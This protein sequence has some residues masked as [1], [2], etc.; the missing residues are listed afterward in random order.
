MCEKGEAATVSS[1]TISASTRS[2][3]NRTM[4]SDSWS[5]DSRAKN[6]SS[7][8][9]EPL[10]KDN[11]NKSLSLHSCL[12]DTYA[13]KRQNKSSSN[14]PCFQR[15]A[16]LPNK[17]LDEKLR[18]FSGSSELDEVSGLFRKAAMLG[19]AAYLALVAFS[20]MITP[21]N[22]F[23]SLDGMERTAH[24]LTAVL[25]V[26]TNGSRIFPLLLRDDRRAFVGSG[27]IF[28]TVMVQIIAV[29]ANLAVAL[30]PT[31]V[32]VDKFTGVRS[33]QLRWA[34]MIPL[35]FLMSF[36]TDNVNVQGLSGEDKDQPRYRYSLRLAISTAAGLILPMATDTL[37]WMVV[38][39]FS[40][41]LYLDIFCK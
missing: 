13:A 37:T 14:P 31:P 22:D 27:F 1:E 24:L 21:S 5:D 4:S 40:C 25:I 28:G 3:T 34:E 26:V 18:A 38:M 29:S 8:L 33:H 35:C 7:P 32:A 15:G 23:E 20:F 10:L 41:F 12:N 39:C 17:D 30:L 36:F 19:L 6:L 11:N 16:I 2:N 9:M